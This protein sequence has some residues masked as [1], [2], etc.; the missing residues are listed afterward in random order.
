MVILMILG[1]KR[2]GNFEDIRRY[3]VMVILRT[4][5]GIESQ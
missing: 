5:D 2:Y 4:Y 3:R 1:G